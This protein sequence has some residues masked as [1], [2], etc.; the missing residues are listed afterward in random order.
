MDDNSPIARL[1]ERMRR[2]PGSIVPHMARIAERIA[3]DSGGSVQGAFALMK[4]ALVRRA[5]GADD[6]GAAEHMG[7]YLA[8]YLDGFD[9]SL[10]DGNAS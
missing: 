2:D 9:D 1:T 5:A 3:R 8:G 7:Y 10:R 4:A 6:G